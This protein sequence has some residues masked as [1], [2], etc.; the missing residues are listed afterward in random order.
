MMVSELIIA[1][2]DIKLSNSSELFEM[3]SKWILVSSRWDV[4]VLYA[5]HSIPG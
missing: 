5:T 2:M 3:V 1:L 4:C